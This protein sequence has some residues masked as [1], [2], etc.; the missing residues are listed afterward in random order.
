MAKLDFNRTHFVGAQVIDFDPSCRE[1]RLKLTLSALQRGPIRFCRGNL[2]AHENKSADYLFLVVSG[3]VR[4]CKMFENG[5]RSI[6]AFYLSG[7]LFGWRNPNF[8]IEAATDAVV[9][10]IKRRPLI[11][12]AERENRIASFLLDITSNELRRSQD[13]A[14][15]MSKDATC[16]VAAFIVE[17]SKRS[18]GMNCLHLPMSHQDIADYL[19]LTIETLSRVI[20]GLEQTGLVTRESPRRLIIRDKLA[21]ERMMD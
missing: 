18:G 4:S 15:L 9:L 6:G 21:L 5:N 12:I 8:S 16:R 17:L 20:T 19:G 13:H 3:V 2:I 7:D 11:S 1:P 10:F 14:L